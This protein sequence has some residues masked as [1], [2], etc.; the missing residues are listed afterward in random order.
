M[1][2]RDFSAARIVAPDPRWMAL[3]KL[4]LGNQTKR[5][6]DKADKDRRQGIALLEVIVG[7]MPHYPMDG[8]FVAS[9]PK[10]LRELWHAQN[11]TP[12]NSSKSTTS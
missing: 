3:H 2:A 1:V 9:L 6:P 12:K 8:A 5:H 7:T 10:V 4:W 11:T